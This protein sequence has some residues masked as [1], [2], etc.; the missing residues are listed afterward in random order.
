MRCINQRIIIDELPRQSNDLCPGF[1]F[2]STDE[3]S[4]RNITA[5]IGISNMS[6]VRQQQQLKRDVGEVIGKV[7]FYR[8][9][10]V[11]VNPVESVLGNW[12]K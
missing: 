1:N 8:D 7:T 12:A 6:D 11:E 2:S 4:G 3:A 5:A 9:F 10:D